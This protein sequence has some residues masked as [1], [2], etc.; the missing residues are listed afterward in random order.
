MG[1]NAGLMSRGDVRIKGCTVP[2]FFQGLCKA[3]TGQG[4]VLLAL[5]DP[6]VK[7]PTILF[8]FLP[9]CSCL[10]RWIQLRGGRGWDILSSRGRFSLAWSLRK[11]DHPNIPPPLALKQPEGKRRQA[12]AGL[13]PNLADSAS[14]LMESG[15]GCR[16][17]SSVNL[18]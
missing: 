14:E 15:G 12:R 6:L 18:L 16:E 7:L 10:K 11:K 1:T 13:H 9:G 8:S 5:G 2:I 3:F 17:G 4:L